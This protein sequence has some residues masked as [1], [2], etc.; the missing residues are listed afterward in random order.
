MNG[1]PFAKANAD[2]LNKWVLDENGL[3]IAPDY[4]GH[5]DDHFWAKIL[6][7]LKLLIGAS[8]VAVNDVFDGNHPY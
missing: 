4:Q 2:S 8:V 5:V 3:Q 1:L 7:Y 6:T